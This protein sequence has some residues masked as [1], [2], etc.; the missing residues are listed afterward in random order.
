MGTTKRLKW[1]IVPITERALLQRINRKLRADGEMLKHTRGNGRAAAELGE[2]YALDLHRNAITPHS[3]MSTCMAGGNSGR[4]A[5]G[6]TYRCPHERANG[7]G[8]RRQLANWSS[9]RSVKRASSGRSRMRITSPALSWPPSGSASCLNLDSS[10][11]AS[12]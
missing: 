5:L 1:A 9:W 3:S 12:T 11:S 8:P 7:R 4:C 10:H 6:S 2:Y